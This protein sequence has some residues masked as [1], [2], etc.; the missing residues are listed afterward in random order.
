MY[1][2]PPESGKDEGAS[3]EHAKHLQREISRSSCRSEDR[4]DRC[5][6]QNGCHPGRKNREDHRS[7]ARDELTERKLKA[8]IRVVEKFFC[9]LWWCDLCRETHRVQDTRLHANWRIH[10][11][12]MQ[13]RRLEFHDSSLAP[14]QDQSRRIGRVLENFDGGSIAEDLTGGLHDRIIWRSGTWEDG[15]SVCFWFI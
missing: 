3:A 6:R 13:Q 8:I 10:S 15:G 5:H 2:T 11:V 9:G 1:V 14:R 12:G 7:N 4:Q